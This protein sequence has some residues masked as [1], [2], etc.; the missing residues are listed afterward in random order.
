MKRISLLACLLLLVAQPAIAQQAAPASQARINITGWRLEC[1]AQ[2]KLAC[3]LSN[4]IT[5]LPT[6]GL[7]ISMT[8]VP[9]ANGKIQLTMQVPLGAAVGTPISVN[10]GNGVTQN[11]PYLTCSQQGCFATATVQDAVL[12]AM[13]AG[14]VEM[15]VTYTILDQ[16]LTPHDI[17]ASIALTGFP[18]VYDKLK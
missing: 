9:V 16:T 13:R 18:E 5:Q 6:G 11:Y 3:H 17:N 10:L 7:I 4:Q 14:K 12:T 8:M 1:D 2:T 15:K